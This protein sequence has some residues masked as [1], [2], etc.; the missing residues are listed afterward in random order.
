VS[1][2]VHPS[3]VLP[4]NQIHPTGPH[5][6]WD[7]HLR[8]CHFCSKHFWSKAKHGCFGAVSCSGNSHLYPDDSDDDTE[9]VA[10]DRRPQKKSNTITSA[11]HLPSP[12]HQPAP[13]PPHPPATPTSITALHPS[14]PSTSSTPPCSSNPPAPL[15]ASTG[16]RRATVDPDSVTRKF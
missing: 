9:L 5:C 2:S 1:A 12:P 10:P 14:A 4:R 11:P 7:N 16:Q 13:V 15:P 8:T 6:C 3:S